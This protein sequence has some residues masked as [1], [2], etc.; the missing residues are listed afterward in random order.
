[1]A[2]KGLSVRTKLTFTIMGLVILAVTGV[3]VHHV[4]E[5]A[6]T[7][8]HLSQ[9]RH[10]IFTSSVA[11]KALELILTE[12]TGALKSL[13][14]D[15]KGTKGFVYGIIIDRENRIL[16]STFEEAIP[17]DIEPLLR[18]EES[19]TIVKHLSLPEYGDLMNIIFPVE[20]YGRL[21][22][23]YRVEGMSSYIKEELEDLIIVYIIAIV[24]GFLLSLFIARRIT[25]PLGAL[26]AGIREI[27]K[28]RT[29]VT[30]PVQSKDE[31]GEVASVFN[32]TMAKLRGYAMS[33]EERQRTQENIVN[34]LNLL[35]TA[36]EGDLT[37][38]AEVTPDIFGSIADAFNLMVEGLADLIVRVKDAAQDIG[39]ESKKML[40]V[41]KEM[42]SDAEKQLSEVK[43]ATEAVDEAAL[44]AVRISEMTE[45]AEKISKN[46]I[47]ATERGSKTVIES[48]DGI[49]LIRVTIQAINKRMKFLSEKL[50]EIGTISQLITEIANRTNLLAINASIEASRAGEQGKG[51][52]VIAEEI[53]SLAEKS[54]RSTKQIGDILGSIQTESAEVTRH[55]EEVTNFVERET[56]LASEAG[57]VFREIE[58]AIKDVGGIISKIHTSAEGQK[59]LTSKVVIS[60]EEVQ[61]VALGILKIVHDF[62]DISKTLK[63]TSERLVLHAGKFRITIDEKRQIEN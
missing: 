42:E 9:E 51:F 17:R 30:L 6:E 34:F 49:Q 37:V 28:G 26:M 33:E 32:E 52:I 58:S 55:L 39:K 4:I 24:A 2:K 22:I 50:M 8:Q 18:I 60:I 27:G 10:V 15:V 12:D 47:E 31:F 54:A 44:S 53:R 45:S 61:R 38:K 7:S 5:F 20:I 21:I 36:S 25:K 1:M 57:S 16:A 63:D 3:F 46:A 59:E 14:Q 62:S 13:L 23:G 35:S 29:D 56:A 40:E 19:G 43:R 48:I 11:G 41:L